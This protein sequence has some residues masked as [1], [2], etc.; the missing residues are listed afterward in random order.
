MEII[1]MLEG[2]R[3]TNRPGT[4][5]WLSRMPFQCCHTSDPTQMSLAWS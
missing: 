2:P 5:I 1:F 3:Q 4:D